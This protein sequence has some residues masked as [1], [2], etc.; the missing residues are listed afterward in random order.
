MG[1]G[2]LTALAT[3]GAAGFMN[4][5]VPAKDV[6][7][8]EA[9]HRGDSFEVTVHSVSDVDRF[10][11]VEP[12]TGLFFHARVAGV[13]PAGQCWV[14]ESLAAAR[15]LLLGKNVR[16]TVRKDAGSGDDRIA[17][18]VRLPDGADYAQTV[19]GDGVVPADLSARD[20]LA[21]VEAAARQQ[22]RGL[23]S[24]GC[25][26]GAVTTSSTPSSTSSSPAPTTTTTTPPVPG[27]SESPEPEEPET[28][29]T[30]SETTLTGILL[31]RRCSEEGARKKSPSGEEMVCAR[32]GKNQLR[33]RRAD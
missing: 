1:L 16:L 4:A 25:A 24:V 2:V 32:N 28:T 22:H 30:T 23:W 33:W 8:R 19:V 14:S 31:G 15:N 13:R 27:T 29:T 12:A 11:G 5:D 18:D 3:T 10:E 26:P 7:P 21:P 9:L 17:V 6:A 20:E